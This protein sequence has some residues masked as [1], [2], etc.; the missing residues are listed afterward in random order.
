MLR[1]HYIDGNSPAQAR[2]QIPFSAKHNFPQAPERARTSYRGD[3]P[4]RTAIEGE[5]QQTQLHRLPAANYTHLIGLQEHLEKLF[6]QLTSDQPPWI[7]SIEGLGGLGKTTLADHWRRLT[8]EKSDVE[9]AWITA[10]Q[11]IFNLGGSIGEIAAPDL[12]QVADRSALFAIGGS[13]PGLL[14]IQRHA[15]CTG[16]THASFPPHHLYR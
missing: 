14:F 12:K 5:W 7:L 4:T 10:K 8:L 3:C 2:A 9:L 1:C 16:A 11:Q 15:Q 13:T 6:Q